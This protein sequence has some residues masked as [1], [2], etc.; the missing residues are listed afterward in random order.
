MEPSIFQ[1]IRRHSLRQQLWIVLITAISL[2]F[3]Y[4]SLDLPK[5]IIN[6]A[7]CGNGNCEFPV[8][9]MGVPLE[10][11]PYLM[12]LSGLFLLLVLINGGFK[13]YINRYKGQMGERM[14]RR[15]R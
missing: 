7:I 8:S 4:V 6:K 9:V 3:L 2:P 11:V 1:F 12:L 5:T 15:L 13:Y 14:L 10:Q